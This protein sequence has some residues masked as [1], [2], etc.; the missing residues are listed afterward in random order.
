V[1][2]PRHVGQVPIHHDMRRR[3]DTSEFYG[4][5]VDREATPRF[6]FGH[7]RSY[8][9]FAYGALR[10]VAG[11]TTAPT[12]I[13]VEVTNTG[14]LDGDEVVQL[15]ATDD[16]ASV[17]RPI[18]E[19]V[20]FRRIALPAGASRTVTFT[21]DPSRL[22]FHGLDHRLVTEP[23]TFTFR[24]GGT[25]APAHQQSVQVSLDGDIAE[26][27]RRSIVATTATVTSEQK[28]G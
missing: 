2:I 23:G 26:Y 1:T 18:T 3:G 12:S 20:G 22:A 28:V 16:I 4:D 9:T 6:A 7:G 11:S 5:Y 25:S 24:V 17:A 15:Y 21:V 19:L 10:S 13:S 27:A 14:D 8:T